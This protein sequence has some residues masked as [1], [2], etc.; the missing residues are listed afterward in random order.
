MS[1]D[2][3][4]DPF[5][6]NG[7]FNNKSVISNPPE[8]E[9]EEQ[10]DAPSK[11]ELAKKGK[12][13]PVENDNEKEKQKVENDE[14]DEEDEP[15]EKYL[16]KDQKIQEDKPK[17]K[18]PDYKSDNER[19]QKTLK[20]T[21]KSFHEDRK[22]LS[23]YRKAVNKFVEDSV[24]TEEEAQMLLD[25]TKFEGEVPSENKSILDGYVEIWNKEIKYMKK[26]DRDAT[27]IDQ[28]IAAF[29]HM[30]DSSS[31]S[32]KEEILEDLSYY[33]DDE[34]EFTKRMLA[35][36]REYNDEVYSDLRESGGIRNVKQKYQS[37]IDSLK[38]E[39]DKV[40]EKYS[41]LKKKHQDYDADPANLRISSGA[42]YVGNEK[43]GS[44]DFG[45]L[46]KRQF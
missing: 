35:L 38:K 42:A 32:E 17:E 40:N 30:Y 15:K 39:L 16:K 45:K 46:F 18:V 7:I 3:Q 13:Q 26:Y 27:D 36:G 21:Q 29:E 20:D 5:D 10:E 28:W 23:A 12:K 6:L 11:Q 22:K 34:V 31:R 8:P 44:L 43:D 2:S 14:D 24:L 9:E 4:V 37:E 19:L 25:H 33:E 1:Q 41:K